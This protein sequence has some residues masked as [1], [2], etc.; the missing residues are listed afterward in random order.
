MATAIYVT[1][2]FNRFI[3]GFVT[4]RALSNYKAIKQIMFGSQSTDVLLSYAISLTVLTNF[5]LRLIA[6]C[7][8]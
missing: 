5:N 6:Y 7:R 3:A 4:P 2:R 1:K 8:G